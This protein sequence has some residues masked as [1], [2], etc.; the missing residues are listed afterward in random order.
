MTGGSA[1]GWPF[2]VKH[3]ITIYVVKCEREKNSAGPFFLELKL[4]PERKDPLNQCVC[5]CTDT[6]NHNWRK[7]IWG[8]MLYFPTEKTI[9]LGF[10]DS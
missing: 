9:S 5:A 6:S 7:Q 4:N 2:L 1:T 3:E 8:K 10:Q